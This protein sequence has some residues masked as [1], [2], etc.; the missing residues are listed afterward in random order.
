MRCKRIMAV[1]ITAVFILSGV[2]VVSN[3]AQADS[4]YVQR[5]TL[6]VRTTIET[7]LGDTAVGDLDVFVQSVEGQLYD[8]ISDDWKEQL[9][10]WR[11]SG[12]YNNFLFNPVYDKDT[13]ELYPDTELNQGYTHEEGFDAMRGGLPVIEV[14]GEWQFNPFADND[15]RFAVNHLIDRDYIVDEMYDGFANPRY[16]AMGI[17]AAG[18]EDHYRDIVERLG[19]DD[20]DPELGTQMIQD[21]ME[22]W[23][24]SGYIADYTGESVTGN[25]DDGWQFAGEDIELIWIIRIDDT[26]LMIGHYLADIIEDQGFAVDRNEME[27][28]TAFDHSLFSDPADMKY[29]MYTGGWV[30]RAA[31]L[32][33]Q[34]ALNQMYTG[35]YGWSPG[36]QREGWWQYEGPDVIEQEI[37]PDLIEGRMPNIDAYWE[38]MQTLAEYGMRSGMRVF[39]VTSQDVYAYDSSRV[40]AAA[41]DVVTGWAGIYSPRTLKLFDDDHL[42]VA[43]YSTKGSLYMDNWNRIDGSGETN[44]MQQDMARDFTMY[45]HPV[46]GTPIGIRTDHEVRSDYEWV[47]DGDDFVLEKNVDVPEDAWDYDPETQEWIQVGED[48]TAAI[49]VTYDWHENADGDLGTYHD[50]NPLTYRDVFAWYAFSKE[51][52]FDTGNGYYYS[53]WSTVNTGWFNNV[54]GIE[55]HVE[56]GEVHSYTMYGDYTFPAEDTMASYFA[57]TTFKPWQVYEAARI[58]VAQH[59]D[60]EH[61]WG[62]VPG[63]GETWSWSEAENWIHFISS[64][65]GETFKAVMEN[66]IAE[67]WTPAYFDNM[68]E[69]LGDVDVSTE[70]QR[71]IDF[72]DTYDHMFISQG[73]FRI[74]EIDETNMLMELERWGPEDGYPLALDHWEDIILIR[75]LELTDSTVPSM[76]Y[77]DEEFEVSAT[78]RIREDYPE[79]RTYDADEGELTFRL[80]VPGEDDR[81]YT[82]TDPVDGEF[83]GTIPSHITSGLEGTYE[84]QLEGMTE[85]ALASSTIDGSLEILDEA[86]EA[87]FEVF[88]F[89]VGPRE[90]YVPLDVEITAGIENI[91]DAE[92]NISLYVDGEVEETFT[93]NAGETIFVKETYTFEE[94][95]VYDIELG[96]QSESVAVGVETYELTIIVE[97]EGEVDIEPDQVEYEEGTTVT[98]TAN[99][100]DGWELTGWQGTDEEGEEITLTMDEDKEI[101]ANFQEYVET[102]DITVGPI[103]DVDGNYVDDATVTLSWN[104]ELTQTSGID[105]IYTFTIESTEHPDDINFTV[106]IDHDDLEEIKTFTFT[107]SSSPEY[108]IDEI[109]DVGVEED[110]GI[111]TVMLAGLGLVVLIIIIIA[112]IFKKKF[113]EEDTHIEENFSK[114]THLEEDKVG[115]KSSENKQDEPTFAERRSKLD[116]ELGSLKESSKFIKTKDIES[117]I[118]NNELDKAHSLI[119]NRKEKIQKIKS[120]EKEI[121]KLKDKESMIDTKSIENSLEENNLKKAEE[122]LKTLIEKYT[123]YTET[124][125]EL[126]SLDNRKSLLAEQLADEKIDRDVFK[127]AR[128][129]IEHKKANLE[130]KLSKLRKEVIYEDYQKPF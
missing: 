97:G 46:K 9:G 12:S 3:S 4:R 116:K 115:Q 7:G 17:E 99:P 83:M 130:E 59:P 44:S 96:D 13:V 56:E 104:P 19:V 5:I 74:V 122:E 39:V 47:E 25:Q 105:G 14:D 27:S 20:H 11:S 6:E 30:A 120:I 10:T 31:N 126:E 50:G 118:K 28:E 45:N 49:A 114:R 70:V 119:G 35:W 125:K 71:T 85:V 102:Y 66:M 61:I 117:A 52:C 95:G 18:Y 55:F 90:G 91:G 2:T 53:P 34:A 92:G 41:I 109:G 22:Y 58:M 15:I 93:I 60:E 107:G 62:G 67:D 88:D 128:D 78:A 103:T 16:M 82:I 40:S 23:R 79:R 48:N 57:Q 1:L 108:Q 33:Q 38:S 77:I 29:H 76:I 98:L 32:Y 26:R 94:P 21:R 86:Q 75:R 63:A 73:P 121:S 80:I 106:T 127:S 69:F 68:P 84:W 89:H 51:L 124:I 81:T 42:T 100:A 64:T 101:T 111:D 8:G 110:V 24:D 43:Q 113:K 65:Q 112:F 72:F 87:V 123:K 54:Q 129:D 36:L 37:G